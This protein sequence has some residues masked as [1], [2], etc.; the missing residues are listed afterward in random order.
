MSVFCFFCSVEINHGRTGP[1]ETLFFDD[2]G[3]LLWSPEGSVVIAGGRWPPEA[4]VTNAPR[5]GGT[6]EGFHTSK[7]TDIGK[8]IAYVVP[9]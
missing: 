4:F 3:Q 2:K 7:R 8:A 6:H 9:A 5:P 1:R